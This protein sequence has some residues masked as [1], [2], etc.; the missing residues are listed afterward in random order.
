MDR[1]VTVYREPL[2]GTL[3]HSGAMLD[4]EDILPGFQCQVS[5]LFPPVPPESA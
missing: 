1:T 2:K 5:G 3:L 4:G